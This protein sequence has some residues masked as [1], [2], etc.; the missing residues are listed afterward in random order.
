MSSAGGQDV[1]M[2]DFICGFVFGTCLYWYVR[3][4][5]KMSR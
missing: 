1:N 2:M 3:T 4:L 5:I